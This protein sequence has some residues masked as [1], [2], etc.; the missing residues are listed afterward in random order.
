MLGGCTRTLHERDFLYPR[1][2]GVVP[3]GVERRNLELTAAD[4]TQLR[5][6]LLRPARPRGSL[7]YFYG[8]AE[9]IRDCQRRL[10]WLAD[11]FQLDVV[12]VDYRGYGTSDGVP[13][14]QLLMQGA[15]VVYVELGR[16]MFERSPAGLKR[17][18]PVPGG[19]HNGALRA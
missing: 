11:A 13:S 15:A 16:E 10:Y 9:T 7:V 17:W 19:R 6:W 14:L 1:K 8:N 3:D 12:A 5:G 18:C 4:G 2:N